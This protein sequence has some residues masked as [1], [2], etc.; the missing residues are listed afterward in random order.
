MGTQWDVEDF[1]PSGGEWETDDQTLKQFQEPTI[2]GLGMAN[3]P[4]HIGDFSMVE[5]WM[6]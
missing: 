4:S 6:F 2:W 5:V 3:L 1:I